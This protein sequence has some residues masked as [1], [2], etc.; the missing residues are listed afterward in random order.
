MQGATQTE[1]DGAPAGGSVLWR[2]V[3]AATTRRKDGLAIPPGGASQG[4]AAAARSPE[5]AVAG[6]I[7][8]AADRVHR[9]PL[10]FDRIEWNQAALAELGELLP[11]GALISLIEGPGDSLG[12]VAICPGLL[13]AVTEMQTAGRV[14]SR[15]APPR[16]PTRTDGSICADFINATLAELGADPGFWPGRDR[17]RGYRYASHLDDLRALDL[18]LE[19]GTFHLLSVGLRAGEAGQRNG[20]L[21]LAW[22]ADPAQP[23]YGA[24]DDAGTG[25]ADDSAIPLSLAGAVHNAPIELVGVLCRRQISLRE[26]AALAPGDVIAL[27]PDVLGA[28]TLETAMGQVLFRGKLGEMAGRHAL[29]LLPAADTPAA[30]TTRAEAAGA[31][32]G[33]SVQDDLPLGDLDIPDPFRPGLPESP[34]AATAEPEPPAESA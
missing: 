3:R 6:A 30:G 4:R 20:H 5:R 31:F 14:S 33:A 2:H 24:D 34:P 18:L 16:R 23:G 26:L 19:E 25:K 9:M 13:A 22:P 27:P 1:T 17:I 15:P 11:E 29:R 12:V 28:A 7:G 10:F 8:R 21:V 32:T